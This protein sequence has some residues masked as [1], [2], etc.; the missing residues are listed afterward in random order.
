MR[1]ERR[2]EKNGQGKVL[3]GCGGKEK[4][5]KRKGKKEERKEE[6]RGEVMRELRGIKKGEISEQKEARL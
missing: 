2:V 1:G 3:A 6:S 4:K 5:G